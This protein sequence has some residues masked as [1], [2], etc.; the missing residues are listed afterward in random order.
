MY[1]ALCRRLVGS[2]VKV[3]LSAGE[4][5][6]TFDERLTSTDQLKSAVK[7]TGYGVDVSNAAHSHRSKPGCCG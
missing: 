5:T 3:S 1:R 2:V 7:G 6:V 4:A